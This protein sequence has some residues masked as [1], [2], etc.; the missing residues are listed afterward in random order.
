MKLI[1]LQK[2]FALGTGRAAEALKGPV[3]RT[4]MAQIVE[5]VQKDAEKILRD[6]KTRKLVK[7]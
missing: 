1:Q 6:P 7:K 2:L 3:T 4:R 5:K